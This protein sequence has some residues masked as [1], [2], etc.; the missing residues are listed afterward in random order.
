MKKNTFNTWLL[1]VKKHNFLT[2]MNQSKYSRF[3]SLK[4]IVSIKKKRKNNLL[5][6]K[7]Y[8]T[9]LKIIKNV[10]SNRPKYTKPVHPG[11][12]I[13]EW[14]RRNFSYMIHDNC[15]PLNKVYGFTYIYIK[16]R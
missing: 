8:R 1:L 10:I 11:Y 12:F 4:R 14:H 13:N 3:Y 9:K 5:D 2:I 6:K 7:V 16:K 15:I